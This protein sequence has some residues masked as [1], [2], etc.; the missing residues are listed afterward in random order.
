LITYR[1]L[2]GATG[3]AMQMHAGAALFVALATGTMTHLGGL[4]AARHLGSFEPAE[5]Y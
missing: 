4:F 5:L 2:A 3:L 1:F